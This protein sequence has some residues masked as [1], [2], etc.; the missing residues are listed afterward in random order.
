MG[1][2]FKGPVIRTKRAHLLQKQCK[3]KEP[4]PSQLLSRKG[5][6]KHSVL[7]SDYSAL[8]SLKNLIAQGP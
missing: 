6:G 2:T 5:A 3:K 7:F 4:A 8:D 1:V